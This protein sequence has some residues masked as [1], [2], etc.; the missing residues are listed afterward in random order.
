MR[1]TIVILTGENDPTA[2]HLISAMAKRSVATLR[3]D[4][5]SFPLKVQLAASPAAN[6]WSGQLT[7]DEWAVDLEA[8]TSIWYRRP[9]HYQVSQALPEPYHTFAENEAAKG[10]GGIL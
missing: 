6:C 9:S 1:K 5:S 8:I 10:L 2:D 7:T 4:P 3:F